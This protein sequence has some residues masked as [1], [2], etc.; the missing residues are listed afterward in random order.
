MKR[1]KSLKLEVCKWN[2]EKFGNV[3]VKFAELVSRI[4]HLDDL[5]VDGNWSVTFNEERMNA[6]CELKVMSFRKF[7]MDS[8]KAKVRWMREGDHNSNFFLQ[9]FN[10]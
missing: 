5:E 8:Q 7:Q 4:K 6:R 9:L 10:N 1:L 3:E 2:R